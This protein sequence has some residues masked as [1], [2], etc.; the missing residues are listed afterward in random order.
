LQSLQNLKQIFD[1]NLPVKEMNEPL[2]YLWEV[3]KNVQDLS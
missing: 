2:S 3:I 1:K